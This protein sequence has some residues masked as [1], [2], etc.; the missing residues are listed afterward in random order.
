MSSF[1]KKRIFEFLNRAGKAT[2]AGGDSDL[3]NPER[4][5]FSEME[6]SEGDLVYRDSY[7]GYHRSRGMEVIRHKGEPIWSSSYGG[8]MLDG[9][10]DLAHHTFEFLKKAL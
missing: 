3:P 1:D 9:K 7:I 8:G 2:Y 4:P 5:N 10:N 6:Y